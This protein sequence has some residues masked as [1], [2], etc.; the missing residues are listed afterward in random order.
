MHIIITF[1]SAHTS[2]GGGAR[3]CLQIAR[4]LEKIGI[5]VTLMPIGSQPPGLLPNSSIPVKPIQLNRY[6]YFLTSLAVLEGVKNVT[7]EK[8]VDAV[9]CWDW[10]AAFLI[11]YLRE[12]KIV[13]GMIAAYP[14]YEELMHRSQRYKWLVKTAN[15]WFRWRLFKQANVVFVSSNYTK[16]ELI[17]LFGVLPEKVFITYRGI[18]PIFHQAEKAASGNIKNL[19]FYGSLAPIKGLLDVI[20]ALGLV[21]KG[22]NRDWKLRIAGWGDEDRVK[23]TAEKCGIAENIQLLG[24]LDPTELINEMAWADLAVLPSQAESFG[25]SIAE[26]QAVG[27]PVISYDSGS[28]PEVLK[29]GETGWLVPAQKVDKL[30]KAIQM[31]MDHPSQTLE[32]GKAGRQRVKNLFTWE[33]TAN[34]ILQ[35]IT[36]AQNTIT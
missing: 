29:D 12:N 30:A 27:L 4:H 28:I 16:Q 13:F 17:S 32:M 11:R 9:L 1:P 2:P 22:G 23:R 33:K 31:A 35:G 26:A 7:R 15:S 20:Q 34:A 19:I 18:D 21:A 8:P 5:D 10:E 25:R 3:S 36:S 24:T 6:H 14:S